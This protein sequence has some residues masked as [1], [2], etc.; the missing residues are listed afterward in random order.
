M[1]HELRAS[2][3]SRARWINSRLR[4]GTR[5]RRSTAGDPEWQTWIEIA[6]LSI[7]AELT[8]LG[9]R[10]THDEPDETAP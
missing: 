2:D 3:L 7:A 4:L 8:L 6:F 9:R 5:I 1:L 10:S